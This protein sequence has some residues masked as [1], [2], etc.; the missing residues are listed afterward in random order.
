MNEDY[1]YKGPTAHCPKCGEDRELKVYYFECDCCEALRCTVCDR[2]GGAMIDREAEELAV[3]ELLRRW[4][5]EEGYEGY[6]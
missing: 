6:E 1:P 3:K 4:P 2:I 5:R